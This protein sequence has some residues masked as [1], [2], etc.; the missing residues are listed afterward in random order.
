MQFKS[1]I[2]GSELQRIP[3]GDGGQVYN[4][5]FEDGDVIN[6]Q[7]SDGFR[8]IH[9]CLAWP[10]RSR[11]EV[12]GSLIQPRYENFLF[13]GSLAALKKLLA[14]AESPQEFMDDPRMVV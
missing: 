4:R 8:Q 3:N 7:A 6:L 14:E 11:T 9:L 5:E 1:W 2:S 12:A 13:R 10:S